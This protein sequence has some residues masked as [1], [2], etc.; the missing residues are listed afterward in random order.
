MAI[1]HNISFDTV[2]CGCC[3]DNLAMQNRQRNY[4]GLQNRKRVLGMQTKRRFISKEVKS[5]QR[6]E[7]KTKESRKSS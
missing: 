4:K 5:I 1:L 7:T 6:R 2:N 3:E